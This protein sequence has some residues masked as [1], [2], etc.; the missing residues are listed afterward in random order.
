MG[1]KKLIRIRYLFDLLILAD[2]FFLMI[3]SSTH[4]VFFKTKYFKFVFQ[5]NNYLISKTN[6]NTKMYKNYFGNK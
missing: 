5:I 1:K 4:Y 2:G 3:S 6:Q